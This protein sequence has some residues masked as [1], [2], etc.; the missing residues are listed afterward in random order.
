MILANEELKTLVNSGV[1]ARPDQDQVVVDLVSI[2]LHLSDTFVVYEPYQG[3]PLT[4][5]TNMDT[6]TK[7]ICANDAYILVPMGKVLAC[8]QEIIRMPLDLMGFVQTKGSLARGFLMA[9]L[10]DG[11][12]DP[13]YAGRITLE[14]VNLSDFNY[15]LE[16]GMPIA[17]L[18]F[19]ALSSP[20][21]SGYSGRYQNSEEPTAMREASDNNPLGKDIE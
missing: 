1:V 13:G 7:R 5:P 20:V 8:S 21:G 9:H 18:F 19:Y 10:C 3:E 6:C 11:Q 15:R 4:P 16:P 2:G 17:Q 14:I 12:I